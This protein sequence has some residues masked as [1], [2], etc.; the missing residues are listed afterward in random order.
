MWEME[1][2]PG[3][4]QSGYAYYPDFCADVLWSCQT[5]FNFTMRRCTLQ[6]RKPWNCQLKSR[7]MTRELENTSACCYWLSRVTTRLG[8]PRV[9][10]SVDTCTAQYRE[11]SH[12]SLTDCTSPARM[13]DQRGYLICESRCRTL[14]L[15]STVQHKVR[16]PRSR[17]WKKKYH[18][19]L[20]V[21][22]ATP[23]QTL[24]K[25]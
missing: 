14:K 4:G 2:C 20:R 12:S 3:G 16:C 23:R 8:I 10:Y 5:R 11:V 22:N 17:N 1:G 24:I 19:Y 9:A 25:Q 7:R 15:V 6:L 18:V 13:A 21:N